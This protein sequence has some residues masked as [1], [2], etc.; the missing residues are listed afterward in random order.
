[1]DTQFAERIFLIGPT[2]SGKTTVGRAVAALLGWRF[3]DTD[4]LAESA[5]GK[6]IPAIFAEDGEPHFREL[7]CAALLEAAASDRTVIA[8]GAGIVERLQNLDLMR[9]RGWVVLLSCDAA[10]ALRRVRADAAA[11]SI[12]VGAMRPMLAD[13]DPLPHVESLAARR[14]ASYQLHDEYVDTGDIAP[15][16]AAQRI[17]AGLTGRGLIPPAGAHSHTR[18]VASDGFTYDAVV[19]WGTFAT[20]G[21]RL[22]ALS[23]RGRIFIVADAT[24]LAF[25][26]RPLHEIFKRAEI[27]E[28]IY[29]VPSGETS[30]SS[31]QLNAVYDWLAERRAERGDLLVAIGGGVVGD[32]AGFAAATYLRGIPLVHVPTTLLAQVD[33]SIGGKTG[34]NHPRGKNLIGAFYPPRL[35]IADPAVLLSLP[36]RQRAEGWAE[37]VKLGVALDLAYFLRIEREVDALLRMEPAALTE[38]IAGSVALKAS[39]V[40]GDERETDGGRRHLLNYGHTIGHAIEAV[41]GYGSWLHGEAVAVGMS[42]AARL[43]LRLGITPRE[44]VD[45]QDALLLR[46][47][48]PIRADGMLVDAL[49]A[50]ALW[51]KKVSRGKVRWVLPTRLGEATIVSDVAESDVQAVLQEIGAVA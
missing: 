16:A 15:D 35:V 38:A 31:E 45:R 21:E 28:M 3:V 24:V 26:Q 32:L 6:S 11:R 4:G 23:N 51:D 36:A 14:S 5:A 29:S 49:L 43:G 17:V 7:E 19:T 8:T 1:M 9:S 48:L 12:S 13:D 27:T 20:L 10:T 30:K 47:G 37:V 39:V 2:G 25:Y 34:I 33:S 18:A 22:R 41:A 42:T 44:V 40:E 46:F 50:A